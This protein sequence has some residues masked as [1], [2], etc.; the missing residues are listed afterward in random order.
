METYTSSG[1]IPTSFSG[2]TATIS[3]GL[4][5][6]TP[7]GQGYYQI[8]VDNVSLK[9]PPSN[10]SPSSS[11]TPAGSST[12][13]SNA[14]ASTTQVVVN[15]TT[16]I[17]TM[18]NSGTDLPLFT[19][20]SSG[21]SNP[22]ETGVDVGE[23]I[24]ST[25]GASLNK[26]TIIGIA[27]AGVSLIIVVALLWW[28]LARRKR[29]KSRASRSEG[30]VNPFLTPS[31][32]THRTSHSLIGDDIMLERRSN[33]QREMPE[34]SPGVVSDA[35]QLRQWMASPTEML[36][37]YQTEMGSE[38]IVRENSEEDEDTTETQSPGFTLQN[39]D[40]GG[41]ESTSDIIR[42]RER[43]VRDLKR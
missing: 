9:V 1:F 31:E 15:G 35:E 13:A 19:Q 30:H 25:D 40:P 37:P 39:Q 36:P 3:I 32:M 12:L 28:S 33:H 6:D 14:Q 20:S 41:G 18:S 26:S 21:A 10:S 29:R 8:Y 27:S 11:S 23:N 17:L 16:S 43:V 34:H 24:A 22:R 38:F 7:T 4:N 2:S 5:G 42:R